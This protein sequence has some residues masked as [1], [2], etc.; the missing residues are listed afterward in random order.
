MAVRFPS[1]PVARRLIEAAGGFVAA[2]S[3]NSS[4]KPS[5]TM[6]E[7][8]AEDMNGRI[9]MILDGGAVGIGLESTIVDVSGDKPTICVLAM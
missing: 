3:A 1:H 5:P 4:G 8:V 6:A 9:D 2:P 7:Y